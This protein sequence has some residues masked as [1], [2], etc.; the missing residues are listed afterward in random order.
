MSFFQWAQNPWGQEILVRISW[1]LFWLALVGGVLFVIG[2]LVWRSKHNARGAINPRRWRYV[3]R[4]M[5][6]L[7]IQRSNRTGWIPTIN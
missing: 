5:W 4:R 7:A 2:H 6:R 3:C 1:D